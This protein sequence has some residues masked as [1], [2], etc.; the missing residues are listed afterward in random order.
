MLR[1]M[2]QIPFANPAK[3]GLFS[4][5]GH[6]DR[7]YAA[8]CRLAVGYPDWISVTTVTQRGQTNA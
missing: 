4:A 2:C 7:P 6:T 8:A 5:L 3:S 1:G